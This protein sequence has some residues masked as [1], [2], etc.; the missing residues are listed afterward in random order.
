MARVGKS[1][2]SDGVSEPLGRIRVTS[3]PQQLRRGGLSFT[4]EPRPIGQ[5]EI[6]PVSLLAILREPGLRVELSQD[7]ETWT[8]VPAEAADELE[9]N[10]EAA[11]ARWADEKAQADAQSAADA[12]EKGE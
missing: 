9:A 2:S 5:L 12:E 3:L 4:R 8:T 11:E 10:L 7:G 1:P 6:P